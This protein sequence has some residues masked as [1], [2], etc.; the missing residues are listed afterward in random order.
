MKKH[1]ERVREPDEL[2]PKRGRP[3]MLAIIAQKGK[4]H[5]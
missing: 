3:Q 1:H 5:D 2:T 4:R